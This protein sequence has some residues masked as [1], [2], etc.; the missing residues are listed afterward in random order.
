MS[1]QIQGKQ[2]KIQFLKTFSAFGICLNYDFRDLF[3]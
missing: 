2:I 1:K 3:D